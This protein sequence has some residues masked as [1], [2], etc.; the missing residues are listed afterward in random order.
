MRLVTLYAHGGDEW[1]HNEW[2]AEKHGVPVEDV[3]ALTDTRPLYEVEFDYDLDTH[4]CVGINLNGV[5]F[6]PE[7]GPANTI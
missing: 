5:R 7:T 1:E 4:E 6:V 3:A 2:T